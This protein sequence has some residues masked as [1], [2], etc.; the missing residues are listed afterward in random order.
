MTKKPAPDAVVEFDLDDLAAIDQAELTIKTRD[1]RPTGW[2]WT[3]AGP[4][5]P[6]TIA[7]NERL[8]KENFARSKAQEIARVN[9][10]KWAPADD[11]ADD[12]IRRTAENLA[13][14]VLGWTPIKFHGEDYPYNTANVVALFLDPARGDTLVTQL[15]E[16]VADEKSF[17]KRSANG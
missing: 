5:H 13:E 6:K 7:L 4:G 15:A 10:K 9:G 3:I 12:I 11:D 14:R 1:G 2:V 8:T 17:M 16:F